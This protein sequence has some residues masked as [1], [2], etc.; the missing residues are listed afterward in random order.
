[1]IRDLATV[2][3]PI[4]ELTADALVI[5]GGIA[6]LLAATRLSRAGR[7]VVVAESGGLT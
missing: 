4:Q 1:M 3:G 2:P 6:G 7:R 5:G